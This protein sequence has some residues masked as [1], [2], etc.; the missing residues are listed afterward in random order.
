MARR[1]RGAQ[2]QQVARQSQIVDR[3]NRAVKE[4][5]QEHD[6]SKLDLAERLGMDPSALRAIVREDWKKFSPDAQEKLLKLL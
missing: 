1:Y 3:R 2:E 4:Y 5:L 6:M